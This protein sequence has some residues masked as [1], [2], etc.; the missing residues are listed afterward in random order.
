MKKITKKFIPI[1]IIILISIFIGYEHPI[2]VEVPKKYVYFVLKKVG[3]RDNFL[4]KQINIKELKT[5]TKDNSIEIKGNSFSTIL[6]KIKSYEGKSAAL[7]LKNKNDSE[8][9]YEIFTQDGFVIKENKAYEMNLPL[10]FYNNSNH[11]SGVKSVFSIDGNYFALI[12]AKKTSCLYA[13]LV[14]LT[15]L[16]EIIKSNCLPDVDEVDFNA[17]GGAYARIK[18]GMLLTVGVPTH[19]SDIIGKLAQLKSSIFGKILFIK[20]KSFLNSKN[21]EYSIFSSGHRNPQGLVIKNNTIFSLE[22]GPQGG[23]ELNIISK[24]QNYGWPIASYGTRY[25]GGKSYITNHS[26]NNFKEPLFT[27][28]QAVAP[29]ALNICPKNLEKYY[30][31]SNC[32]MGLSLRGMSI[33][34][35]LLDSKNSKVIGVESILLD[36]RL[37]HFG[38]NSKTEL[39]LD[40]ENN[41]YITSDHDGLY[42]VKFDKFRQ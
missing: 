26:E 35:F 2:L 41:F 5:H 14:S 1:L 4:D 39:F 22:H 7:L 9:E 17:L 20:D 40:D 33:L 10:F 28:L 24:G 13:S 8:I 23:D 21:N 16:R 30:K 25:Y 31:N 3:L 38:L 15:N 12:S 27:F 36:K 37:R 19:K 32:L 34:I 42:K 11:S 18:D 6:T 29:T